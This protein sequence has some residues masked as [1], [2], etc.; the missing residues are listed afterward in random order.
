MT[1]SLGCCARN[2][3]IGMIAGHAGIKIVGAGAGLFHFRVAI[4]LRKAAPGAVNH[5]DQAGRVNFVDEQLVITRFSPDATQVF[6][7]RDVDLGRPL[8]NISHVL[9]YP[10]LMADMERTL[11]SE[12]MIER[13][14]NTLDDKKTYL[15]RILPYVIPSTTLRGAVATFVDVTAYHDARRLQSI[16]D[17]LPEH[18]AVVGSDAGGLGH[19]V[20]VGINPADDQHFFLKF[21]VDRTHFLVNRLQLFVGA[22]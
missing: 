6:K 17:A 9:R 1:Q 13:E 10:E 14:I 19:A 21:G 15:I 20:E 16:I 3:A 7:L 11:R 4:G 22:L 12:R 2:A 18:I 8:D 5:D